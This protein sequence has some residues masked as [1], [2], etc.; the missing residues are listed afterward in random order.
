[1]DFRRNGP[2]RGLRVVAA[3]SVFVT[4]AGCQGLPQFNLFN[5]G[6][7]AVDAPADTES[8]TRLVERDVEAP[9][10]FQV[11][12]MGL[13][14]GRPSLGGVWV[15]HPDVDEPER[16]IIRNTANSKFVIGALFRREREN[17]GPAIQVSSDAAAALG[18]LAGAPAQL[19][20]TALRRE[21]APA[22]EDGEVE[23]S[24]TGADIE[25]AEIDPVAGAAAAIDAAEAESADSEPSAPASDLDKPFIQIG[26]FS[27]EQNA[28]NTAVTMRREGMVPTVRKQT[29]RG[30][31]FWRVVVGPATSRSERSTL[32][33]KIK[34]VGFE[35]AYAVTD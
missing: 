35:D 23:P 14:D 21:E 13:W 10:V 17:P 12:D 31:T 2:K 1:M 29:S 24:G 8:A 22:G 20:V 32:L 34:D 16:V 19:N 18:L 25:T 6:P 3:F 15:A 28:R 11:T 33:E 5:S 4:L 27:I 30:K 7:E 26:I 9:E